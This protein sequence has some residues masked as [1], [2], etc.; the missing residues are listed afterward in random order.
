MSKILQ[1]ILPRVSADVETLGDYVRATTAAEITPLYCLHGPPVRRS[2]RASV[3]EAL[4]KVDVDYDEILKQLGELKAIEAK[5]RVWCARLRTSLQPVA[6]V[7]TEVLQ[8]IFY[9]SVRRANFSQRTCA[10]A[11]VLSQVCST[12]R[13]AAHSVAS[14]WAIIPGHCGVLDPQNPYILYSRDKPLH[15]DLYPREWEDKKTP[16]Q[17]ERIRSL[18]LPIGSDVRLSDVRLS[19]Y[20]KLHHLELCSSAKHSPINFRPL[21]ELQEIRSLSLSN[22]SLFHIPQSPPHLSSLRLGC[23]DWDIVRPLTKSAIQSV[24]SLH[25]NHIT[26]YGAHMGIPRFPRIHTLELRHCS[27]EFL[28]YAFRMDFPRLSDLT[29]ATKSSLGSR[30]Q[31]FYPGRSSLGAVLWQLAPFLARAAQ[32]ERLSFSVVFEADLNSVQ[33]LLIPSFRIY[34]DLQAELSPGHLLPNLRHLTLV[35]GSNSPMS[36]DGFLSLLKEILTGRIR[37]GMDAK[38]KLSL[39]PNLFHIVNEAWSTIGDLVEQL[40]CVPEELAPVDNSATLCEWC[41]Y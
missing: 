15:L 41:R 34:E 10:D 12:W 6:A 36:P 18:H 27:P 16:M 3:M 7:P 19:D 21:S 40:E 28:N 30:D 14:I 2:H 31:S 38:L 13:H 33:L 20:S 4:G 39:S 29:I 26:G 5:F 17:H 24:E 35:F 11:L 22:V 8:R 9:F 32:I 25:L 1:D 37:F 23:F